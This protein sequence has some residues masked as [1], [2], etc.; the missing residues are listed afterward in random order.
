M[1]AKYSRMSLPSNF[2]DITSSQLLMQ[3]EPQYFY[4]R[5][6]KNAIARDLM[7]PSKLELPGRGWSE[8]GGQ[9]SS[10]E[11]DRLML[12]NDYLSKE[13]A[14]V[15]VNFQGQPGHTM[16]FNRP[17]FTDSTYTQAARKIARGQTISTVGINVQG[18]QTAL[19]LELFAGPY[20]N[21]NTRVAP[22]VID[23]FDA[24]LGIHKASSIHG[25]HLQRDFDKCLD[26][27]LVTLLDTAATTVYPVGMT[28]DND[29]TSKGQFTL[30]YE[31]LSRAVVEADEAH[32]P[33]MG[34]GKRAFVCTSQGAKSLKD[35]PQFVRLAESH[36]DKN[37]LYDGSYFASLPELDVYK[38][39]TLT[40]TDNSSSIEIHTGHLIAP[41]ALMFGMG[42][43][44][45]VRAATNDNYGLDQR[46]IWLAP[47]AVGFADN[48]FCVEVHYT[49]MDQ[50]S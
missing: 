20:D 15:R 42:S 31:T 37:P 47:L 26:S 16:R 41:G 5:L 14:Q 13:L 33:V 24:Q 12:A 2:Y 29:A 27:F 17:K 45:E 21:E 8:A 10:A 43:A 18:E 49:E 22:Y 40:K 32:L 39:E 7:V 6:F 34:N 38:S 9:Y 11:A 19:T 46:V 28:A 35:D 48:R 36:K 23:Q 25:T 30:D 1:A 44:P 3:P 4:A 50:A